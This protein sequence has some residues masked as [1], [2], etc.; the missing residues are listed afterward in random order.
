MSAPPR[1]MSPAD[2]AEWQQNS[3][4]RGEERVKRERERSR[5]EPVKGEPLNKEEQDYIIA[6]FRNFDISGDGVLDKEEIR[7]ILTILNN[8]VPVKQKVLDSIF[9]KSDRDNSG[10]IDENEFLT[11]VMEWFAGEGIANDGISESEEEATEVKSASRCCTM[12]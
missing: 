12:L 7:E 3:V 10:S 5:V 8:D 6:T 9:S 2:K 1:V 4:K 11:V